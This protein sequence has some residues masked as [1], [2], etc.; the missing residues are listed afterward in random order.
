MSRHTS[1][2][3]RIT[4][5]SEKKTREIVGADGSTV[6]ELEAARIAYASEFPL[7]EDGEPDTGNIH[8]NIR[9]LKAMKG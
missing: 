1:L 8:A 6:A 4:E 7:N 3:W 9:K 2:P 5:A